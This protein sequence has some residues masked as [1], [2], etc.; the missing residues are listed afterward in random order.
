VGAL[1]PSR[2]DARPVLTGPDEL[3]ERVRATLELLE[4]RG[5]TLPV[6]GFAANLYG[7]ALPVPEVR[8][9]IDRLS[10]VRLRD[11]HV[12]STDGERL[13]A[14]SRQRQERHP[15]ESPAYREIATGFAQELIDTCPWVSSV[16]IAG[17]LA[18]GGFVE[19]DDVD[20]NLIVEDGTKYITYVLSLALGVRFAWRRRGRPV[21]DTARMP[22][23]SKLICLNV[24]WELG[25][26]SPFTRNDPGMAFELLL[27][28]PVF[29]HEAFYRCLTENPSV[30]AHFP[31][32]A[33]TRN[34]TSLARRPNRLGRLLARIVGRPGP[35]R[36]LNEACF[37]V[38]R[39]IHAW[40]R[41]TR[42]NNADAREHVEFVDA[43]KHPYAILDRPESDRAQLDG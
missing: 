11:G 42:R 37:L 17:S 4:R 36:A 40:V 3:G 6:E 32:M 41:W 33:T 18:T 15:A 20:F 28:R 26:T 35:R 34:P 25:Q 13:V 24:V 10:D 38:S 16:L 12:V 29:G 9:A 19:E 39:A 43:L 21:G 27:N 14:S 7:G 8:T 22:F 30:V 5:Y 1:A 2:T 23:V 31:Q